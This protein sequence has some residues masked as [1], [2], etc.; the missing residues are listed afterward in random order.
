MVHN[1]IHAIDLGIIAAYLIAMVVIGVVV[2]KKVQSTDDYYL[3]GRS[4]GPLVLMAT[5]CATI[6]GGSGL[7]GRAGV[8]Y[9]SGFKAIMTALPYLLGMFIFSGFAGRISA[10][11]TTFN[12]TSIPDLFEQRFGKTAKVILGCLIA[13]T[14][15]GTVAS[16][17]TATATSGLFGVIYTDVFQF[18]MLILFVYIM[19]PTASLAKLGGLSVFLENLAPELS[20]PY[21]DGSI[22]GDIITYFVFTLAG[23]EM[24]QRAFA[25]KSQKAAREGLF[26]G[27][28]VYG[29]TIPLVW[30]MG[31]V[32]HQLVSADKIAQYGSTDAV[33]PALAIEILPVGLTGLALAGILSVI[34]S[35]ADSYLIV[36]VQTCVHDIYKVFKP[37]I[38]EKRELRLTRVF[39][40]VLPL[41]ALV[42]ALYIKN[43]YNILMFAWSFYAAAAGLPAFAALYWKK[44]TKAGIIS[45]MAAGFV[46]CVGWKLIG[47]PFGLGPT[48]PGAIAC[49][50]ALVV[51]SLVT[52]RK[53]PAPFLDP[54]HKT[55]EIA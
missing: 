21:V 39:A 49:A 20:T 52:Y 3:G 54:Y 42:I 8:A 37:D 17:V 22:I 11:G 40:F 36:S 45:G 2:V 34:M 19:I 43:A 23:A 50:A 44:A 31:V 15:M 4:F 18:V 6:I 7:M 47:T 14:M 46:V 48:V 26:L 51:V 9:S 38:P 30:F 29:L 41:G 55:A 35:T 13:F 25:A 27:T 28:F 32:A 16:Q 53:A 1:E 10:V 12:V 24:W 33:V 5:V